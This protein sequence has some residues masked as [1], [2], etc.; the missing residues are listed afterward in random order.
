M[1]D[2]SDSIISDRLQAFTRAL[3]AGDAGGK[4]MLYGGTK[5]TPNATHSQTLLCELSFKKP[6]AV[7]VDNKI[8]TIDSPFSAM[9]LVDGNVT[10]CRLIDSNGNWVADCDAGGQSSNA[11]FRI[12]NENGEVYAGGQVIVNQAQLKE[13]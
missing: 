7:S 8:L 9:A 11:V 2:F 1:I 6:S 12:Q 4:I 10:W 5:P 3:D 13:V